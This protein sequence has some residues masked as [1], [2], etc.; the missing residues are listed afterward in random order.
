[1][2]SKQPIVMIG[3]FLLLN[4]RFMFLSMHIPYEVIIETY[5][6]PQTVD[7]FY[8]VQKPRRS[9]SFARKRVLLILCKHAIFSIRGN[10]YRISLSKY[11]P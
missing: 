3:C 8:N 9:I 10:L 6:C 4:Y 2:S 5:S 1:M 11:I 7:N